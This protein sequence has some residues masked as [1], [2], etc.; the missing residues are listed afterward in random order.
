[1]LLLLYMMVALC[2]RGP[3]NDSVDERQGKYMY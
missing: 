3:Y 2:P 1:M